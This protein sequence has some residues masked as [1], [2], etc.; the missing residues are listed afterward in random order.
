MSSANVIPFPS[1]NHFESAPRNARVLQ[2][3]KIALA[4]C[5][6]KPVGVT[7]CVAWLQQDPAALCNH[8][9]AMRAL[10]SLRDSLFVA[11]G[12]ETEVALLWREALAT[13][14]HARVLARESGADAPLITGVGL[15]HR[16]GE[17]TA[18]RA[19]AQAERE[20]GQ[21]LIGP[22]M[23]EIFAAD[24]GEL[25]SRVTRSW[26]LPG[27]LRLAIIRWREEQESLQRP[28]SVALLMLAQA[29]TTELVHAATCTPGLAEAAAQTLK[30]PGRLIASARAATGEITKLLEGLAP[31]PAAGQAP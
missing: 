11:A 17:I 15:L 25:A 29:L 4:R 9:I 5:P 26:G 19:L 16:A 8:R 2:A 3:F 1:P 6:P 31:L 23:R 18:L 24:D 12:R 21:R 13:A 20:T 27:G 7:A 14:C 22:V 28:E 30:L 10:Q